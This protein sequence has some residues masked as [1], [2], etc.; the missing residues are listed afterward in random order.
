MAS[1]G[2]RVSC[3]SRRRAS[4]PNVST[5]WRC[6]PVQIVS[7]TSEDLP[8]PLTPVKA[9]SRCFGTSTSSSLSLCV[10]SDLGIIEHLL[11]SP[12]YWSS[13][14]SR[15][16]APSN[17][18]LTTRMQSAT[19]LARFLYWGAALIFGDAAPTPVAQP[20]ALWERRR[21]AQAAGRGEWGRTG[22]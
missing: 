7:K 3:G 5:G 15:R 18:A 19:F 8:L 2:G 13:H 12:V 22:G 16:S 10:A 6:T 1:T 11:P 4:V 14:V 20:W 21:M 17:A 9:T